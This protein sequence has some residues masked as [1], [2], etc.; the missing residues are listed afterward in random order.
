MARSGATKLAPALSDPDASRAFSARSSQRMLISAV[1]HTELCSSH[2]AVVAMPRSI[3]VT[4]PRAG[5]T[6]ATGGTRGARAPHCGKCPQSTSASLLRSLQAASSR[7]QSPLFLAAAAVSQGPF[8]SGFCSGG[9]AE[10]RARESNMSVATPPDAHAASTAHEQNPE[11][12]GPR[13]KQSNAQE[14]K[15]EALTPQP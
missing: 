8:G 12:I 3:A 4:S 1:S 7:L 11:P 13:V 5:L 10:P 6:E 14:Q 15:K 9:A 2:A